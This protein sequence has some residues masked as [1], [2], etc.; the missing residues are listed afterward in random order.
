MAATFTAFWPG[1]KV[2]TF[3]MAAFS[4]EAAEKACF[5]TAIWAAA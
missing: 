4:A 5:F 2:R 3:C 1:H